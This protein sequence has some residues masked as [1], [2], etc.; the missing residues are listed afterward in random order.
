MI[1]QYSHR[2]GLRLPLNGLSLGEH[3]KQELKCRQLLGRQQKGPRGAHT[4]GLRHPEDDPAEE[5]P[6]GVQVA[7]PGKARPL[8]WTSQLTIWDLVG[9]VLLHPLCRDTAVW[10]Q[11]KNF[12]SRGPSL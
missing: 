6:G 7:T 10:T 2:G 5:A 8:A 9:Y 12:L 3:S 4:M 1:V 11:G